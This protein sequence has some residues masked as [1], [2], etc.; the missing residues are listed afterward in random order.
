MLPDLPPSTSMGGMVLKKMRPQLQPVP[1]ED[2][3]FTSAITRR[4]IK[5]SI[6]G[7]RFQKAVNV[8]IL[9]RAIRNF[10]CW[11]MAKV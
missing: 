2:N 4:A 10:R 9:Q 11:A 5:H 8:A 7:V 1:D 3:V 6:V